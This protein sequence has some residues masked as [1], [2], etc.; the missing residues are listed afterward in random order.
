M[1]NKATIKP[2]EGRN[3]LLSRKDVA[4]F[5]NVSTETVKRYQRRGILPAIVLNSRVTRYDP[6]D[7]EKLVADGR[8]E[9]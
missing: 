4:S 1:T 8:V 3:A 5:L 9:S 2:N 6:A 7:V